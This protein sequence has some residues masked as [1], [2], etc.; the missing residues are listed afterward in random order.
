MAA[1][2]TVVVVDDVPDN[3]EYL[4]ILLTDQGYRVI[5]F[6]GGVEALES[7]QQERP[8]LLILDVFLPAMDGVELL[9]RIRALPG[10]ENIPAIALTADARSGSGQQYLDSGFQS[11]VTKPIVDLAAFTSE[12]SALSSQGQA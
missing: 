2:K 7:I 3:R 5:S 8:N 1:L 12:I 10:F 11:Y 6:S 4:E 9:R